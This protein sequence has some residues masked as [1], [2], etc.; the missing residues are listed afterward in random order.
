MARL[1]QAQEDRITVKRIERSDRLEEESKRIAAEEARVAEEEAQAARVRVERDLALSNFRATT[2]H[3][4]FRPTPESLRNPIENW[5]TIFRKLLI[6]RCT[7]V[8]S[9]L[10]YEE[11]TEHWQQQWR[12]IAIKCWERLHY[13]CWKLG[14][15]HA[16]DRF[17]IRFDWY[18]PLI[19][20]PYPLLQRYADWHVRF[21][22]W[23]LDNMRLA[24]EAKELELHQ[25][26]LFAAANSARVLELQR[27]YA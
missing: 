24:K 4:F 20:E 10:A 27:L 1:A 15:S 12:R 16:F 5:T 11:A 7:I 21:R 6:D 18:R 2:D 17:F 26:T 22:E 25:E 3:F 9:Y 14:R 23:Q 13:L 19:G 8:H